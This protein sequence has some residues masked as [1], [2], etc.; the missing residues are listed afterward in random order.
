M[1]LKKKFLFKFQQRSRA[2]KKK[3][4]CDLI[5]SITGTVAHQRS[6]IIWGCFCSSGVG[7]IFRINGIL[8]KKAIKKF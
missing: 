6:V 3:G 2:W 1:N 7:S 8:R 5:N 4:H